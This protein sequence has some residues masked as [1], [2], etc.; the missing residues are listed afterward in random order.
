MLYSVVRPSKGGGNLDVPLV[1]DF[2]VIGV[3]AEK[4]ETSY[5]NSHALKAD[6][7]EEPEHSNKWKNVIRSNRKAGNEEDE[8]EVEKETDETFKPQSKSQKRR[9]F[10]KF[11]VV[12]M[13]TPNSS[14]TGMGTLTLLLFECETVDKEE[15]DDGTS[16]NY[17]RGGSG[18]AYEKWWKESE[19]AVVAVLNPKVL[20]QVS[21]HHSY[22]LYSN[23]TH[24]QS[25]RV[26]ART[27][28]GHHA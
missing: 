11:S 8:V 27:T 1:G 16:K 12:D 6:I 17:Y 23:Y 5:I 13:S 22:L 4:G 9:R 15:Y 24:L 26:D 25:L 18:G 2:V 20:K 3:L 19:G 14:T 21:N 10:I 28:F 7:K